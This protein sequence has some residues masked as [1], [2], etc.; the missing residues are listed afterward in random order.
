VSQGGNRVVS[1]ATDEGG[2]N[3]RSAR[4]KGRDR[5]NWPNCK[6]KYV[7][8]TASRAGP[9]DGQPWGETS[10][11]GYTLARNMGRDALHWGQ[12]VDAEYSKDP[13]CCTALKCPEHIP[14]GGIE[15]GLG[16][17][18][19]GNG[20]EKNSLVG[21]KVGPRRKVGGS[22]NPFSGESMVLGYMDEKGDGKDTNA[23]KTFPCN[24]PD[25]LGGGEGKTPGKARK[26]YSHVWGCVRGRP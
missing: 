20:G 15:A 12:L 1:S 18:R 11:G 3:T 23:N 24:H 26:G 13:P 25:N 5:G 8:G 6:R 16:Q 7:D 10:S 19:Q 17:V 22:Y 4:A 2:V 14:W 9:A 21:G